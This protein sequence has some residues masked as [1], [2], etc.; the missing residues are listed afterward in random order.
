MNFLI[1]HTSACY[2]H[3][4]DKFKRSVENAML[5]TIKFVMITS[6]AKI[7]LRNVRM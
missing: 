1:D 7:H 6:C 2:E 5:R 3:D 4:I